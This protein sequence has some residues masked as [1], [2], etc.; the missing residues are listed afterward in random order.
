MRRLRRDPIHTYPFFLFFTLRDG[1]RF[2]G[3]VFGTHRQYPCSGLS[4]QFASSTRHIVVTLVIVSLNGSI[5]VE[6]TA[7]A[8][9][10]CHTLDI[11]PIIV[12][13][14]IVVIHHLHRLVTVESFSLTH[15][16][17]H[18]VISRL[19]PSHL[20]LRQSDD[21]AISYSIG[22]CRHRD[23]VARVNAAQASL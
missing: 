21:F 3:D 17:R 20:R 23:V 9:S 7:L 18:R 1:R 6:I 15:G 10:S 2:G 4:S 12:V 13:G 22:R 5:I 19:I 11:A 8:A 16:R 14:V